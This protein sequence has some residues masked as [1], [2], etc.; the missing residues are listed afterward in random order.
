MPT[1]ASLKDELSA[2]PTCELPKGRARLKQRMIYSWLVTLALMHGAAAVA[3]IVAQPTTPPPPEPTVVDQNN[4]D[5]ASGMFSYSTTELSIG[6]NQYGLAL[7]R[8]TSAGQGR[9]SFTGMLNYH[10]GGEREQN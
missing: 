4:V 8:S 6:P 1:F 10:Q 5:M 7:S 9:D 3:Q 2:M